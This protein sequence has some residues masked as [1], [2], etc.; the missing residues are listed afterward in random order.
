MKRQ[1]AGYAEFIGIPRKV[2]DS[3]AF[4]SLPPIA[5]ALYLDLRRQHRGHN[6]GA[7]A[8]VL[9]GTQDRLG[10]EAYGWPPRSVFKCIGILLEHGLITMTRRGGIA[11]MSKICSLYGFTDLPIAA[12]KE[13][14]IEGSMPSMAFLAF[15]PAPKVKRT[16]ARKRELAARGARIDARGA[17][18]H[19]HAVPITP[20]IDA[21]GAA[22][23]FPAEAT[24]G[25]EPK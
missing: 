20:A 14:G 25:H 23:N 15:T 13:K 16:R 18:T 12:N 3:P 21:R 24:Q 10:L 5:R 11:S 19:M 7:I 6:N 8:A 17:R 9:K 1:R 2:A 4:K 22:T